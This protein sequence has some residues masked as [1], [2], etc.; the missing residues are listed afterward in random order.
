MHIYIPSLGRANKI[1]LGTLSHIPVDWLPHTTVVCQSHEEEDYKKVVEVEWG[2]NLLVLPERIDRIEPTRRFIAMH[3]SHNE[4]EKIVMMDDDLE[5]YYRPKQY[6]EDEDFWKLKGAAEVD[7]E[8]MLGWIDLQLEKYAHC[9][10]SGREG[11]NRVR[12]DT[13][14]NTRYMRVLGYKTEMYQA[15][16]G[17]RVE[18]M[19]DFDVALQLLEAGHQCPVSYYWAQGQSKTQADGGCSSW[20][21]LEVH[22]A[23]AEKLASLHPN[24]VRLREKQNKTDREGFGTRKEVTVYW[25]KAFESSKEME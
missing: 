15:T 9:G 20:R 17:G 16:I 10:I 21:T 19:E 22:N 6:T 11:Q 3:A 18:I 7:M 23:G 4:Q 8:Q 2:A 1:H 12:E 13:V 14:F 5:F 25:K 24:F